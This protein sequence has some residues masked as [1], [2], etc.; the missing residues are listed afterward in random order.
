MAKVI[1][2]AEWAK[3]P[4]KDVKDRLTGTINYG[5][6]RPIA[7]NSPNIMRYWENHASYPYKSHDLWFLTENMRWG[8]ISTNTD[9]KQIIDRVNREDIWRAAAKELN[10]AAAQIPASTS[11]GVETFFDGVK[12]DPSNPTAY[13][14]SLKIKQA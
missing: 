13:L 14:N 6:N 1:S 9:A 2:D 12:F 11:R 8:Q 3:V 4:V 10:L 5:N 7:E